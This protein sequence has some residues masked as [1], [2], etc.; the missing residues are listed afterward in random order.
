MDKSHTEN[1]SEDAKLRNDLKV[2]TSTDGR[3]EESKGNNA[4]WD[5]L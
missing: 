5:V 2:N 4:M 3:K 1:K